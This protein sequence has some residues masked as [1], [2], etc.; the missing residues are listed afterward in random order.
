MDNLVGQS[1]RKRLH[2]KLERALQ[3]ELNKVGDEFMPRQYYIDKWGYKLNE[4]GH[5]DYSEG[6]DFQG[7]GLN[8]NR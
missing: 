3:S 4:G 7:P 6:A 8:K 1:G 5:I 2:K